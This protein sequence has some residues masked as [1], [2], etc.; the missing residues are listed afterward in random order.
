MNIIILI[1]IDRVENFKDIPVN[2][3]MEF[4]TLIN[5]LQLQTNSSDRNICLKVFKRHSSV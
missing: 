2:I 1:S 4:Q 3:I 5:H